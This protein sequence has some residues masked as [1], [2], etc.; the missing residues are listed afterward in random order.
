MRVYVCECVCMC[1]CVCYNEQPMDN[2]QQ[3]KITIP[4]VLSTLN[5]TNDT[6]VCGIFFKSETER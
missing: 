4:S 1:V 5:L 2:L 6:K 3:K